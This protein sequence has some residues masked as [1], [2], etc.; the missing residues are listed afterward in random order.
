LTPFK[1]AAIALLTGEL[2]RSSNAEQLVMQVLVE[3]CGPAL[4][5]ALFSTSAATAD[6]PAGLL[7]GIAGLTPAASGGSNKSEAIV[8]DLQSLAN[9]IAPVAGNRDITIIASP[10]A[11][12]ALVLRLP[13]KVD[14]P[15]LTSVALP[16][17]TVIAIAPRAV[18]SAIEGPPAIEASKFAEIHRETQPG[19]VVDVGGVWAR[20]VASVF[21]TDEVALKLRWPVSWGLRSPSA[22]AWMTNVNW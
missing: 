11:S 7:N 8:D 5:A 10:G 15:I 1:I 21:Q 2:M 4:D 12:A 3:A 17:R 20:P 9:A 16:L 18:A 13:A 19:E 6:Q 14:W 22:I